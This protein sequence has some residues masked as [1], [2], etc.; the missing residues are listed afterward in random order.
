MPA[1]QNL[2]CTIIPCGSYRRIPFCTP[3]HAPALAECPCGNCPCTQKRH[4]HWGCL[5]P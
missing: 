2:P 1:R 5:G 3:Q 4:V